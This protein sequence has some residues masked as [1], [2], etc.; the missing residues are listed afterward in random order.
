MFSNIGEYEPCG[1]FTIGHFILITITI[2]GIFI[3]LKYSIKK[4]KQEI[5]KIIKYIT[6]H[7]Y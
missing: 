5:H 6:L 7:I 2:I 3:A 1:I 4:N